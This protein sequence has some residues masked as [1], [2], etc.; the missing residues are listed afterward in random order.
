MNRIMKSR[1]FF[2]VLAIFFIDF[3]LRLFVPY[4]SGFEIAVFFVG[5]MFIPLIG[6]LAI[7][8]DMADISR[9]E[10]ENDAATSANT[11]N[12]SNKEKTE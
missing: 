2:L 12:F 5:L 8:A 10:D 9:S 4:G 11:N 3:L 6:V 7:L 1:T